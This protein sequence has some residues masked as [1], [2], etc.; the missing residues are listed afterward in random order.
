MRDGFATIL[1]NNFN[2][3]TTTTS[4]AGATTNINP[5]STRNQILAGATT[6][7]YKLPNATNLVPGTQWDFNNNA[8]G[9]LTINDNS[10][11]LLTTVPP[12]GQL[13]VILLDNSSPTGVWDWHNLGPTNSSWGTDE[14][15][16]PGRVSAATAS[17]SGVVSANAGLATTTLNAS[18]LLTGST[19]TFSGIV[20]ANA[21]LRATT[22]SAS[23]VIGASNLSGTNTGDQKLVESTG[24]ITGGALS[25]GTGGAGVATSFTIAAGTGQIVDSTVSPPTITPVSWSQKTDVAVTNILTQL[26]T[27]VAIDSGGNVIQSSTDFTPQQ[28]REYISIGVVVHS[29]QTTVNAVNQA[30]TVAYAP[31]SQLNDLY[32]GL[33]LFNISGNTFSANG[34]NLK[35]NKSVGSLFRRGANYSSLSTNPH[36]IATG[37]L[38]QASLRMQNQTGAGSA[39]GTDVDVANYDVGGVTTAISPGT[40]FS[41]LRVFLF[42]SNLVAVQR[43]QDTYLSFAEAKAAIQTEV[44]VTNSVLAANGLLRGFI[45]AQANATSLSDTAKVFFIESGKFGSSTGVGGLSVSTLQNAY[46]NSSSPEI[47]TNAT[48]LGLTIRCG[49]GADTDIVLE[50]QNSAG[51]TTFSVTGAG[52]LISST[53]SF[54]GMVS[55]DAGLRATTVSASGVIGG[56]N[57]SGTNTGDQTITL[58]GDVSGSGTAGITAVVTR[59]QGTQVSAGTIGVGEVLTYVADSKWSPRAA[60]T[61]TVTSAGFTGSNGVNITGSPI[62]TQGVINIG[63]S[64]ISPTSVTTGVVSASTLNVTGDIQAATGRVTASAA[65]ITALLNGATASFSGVVSANAG[66]AST[67]GSF[68]GA[69]TGS[70][71]NFSG[72][73]SANAGLSTTTL[74]ASGLLSGS[75]AS[76][77]GIVSANAGLR[78]TT[79]SASGVIGGS[80]LSGTNTGDQTITLTGDVSGSGTGT[81]AVQLNPTAVSAGSYTS[82]N[83]TVDSK[84]RITAA[85][86][87]TGGGTSLGLVIT[88]A[89]GNI[90]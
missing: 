12:G 78:A 41:I 57:L 70:T 67:T 87:G 77:S 66:L 59:I 6:Q 37:A 38:T 48:L 11:G 74:N 1:A 17:F 21:G 33:G 56:S 26:V 29:N 84:G 20:S 35:I 75:T 23:G 27:F 88:I 71:A 46:N 90:Y 31:I 83:L 55:A 7:T 51:S 40:R 69:L 82:T 80:N 63:L 60:A 68:S 81:F 8:S 5:N 10:N 15:S 16:F 44:F 52:A 53:A 65:T 3:L 85:S 22:V 54:S 24:I 18:G 25:I 79:V 4:A 43:G 2:G 14:L 72:V 13:R 64:A 86:N 49:S 34:A 39:S 32:Y 61:G 73:V 89:A 58:S 9:L 47:L 42:Q 19:A 62:T 36:V 76:F 45:V 50:S 30:Q 28:Y